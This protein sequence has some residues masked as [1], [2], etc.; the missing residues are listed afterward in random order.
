MYLGS[1]TIAH[2]TKSIHF[3]IKFLYIYFTKV[4]QNFDKH[5]QMGVIMETNHLICLSKA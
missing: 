3:Q 2:Y 1:P 4:L 5:K